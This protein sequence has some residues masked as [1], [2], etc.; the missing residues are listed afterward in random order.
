[1]LSCRRDV[2]P[3][4]R[5]ALLDEALETEE[6]DNTELLSKYRKRLDRCGSLQET[7]VWMAGGCACRLHSAAYMYV[8][9]HHLGHLRIL[10][11]P[12]CLVTAPQ[13]WCGA[14]AGGGQV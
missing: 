9:L 6:Q 1:M 7:F 4:L 14:V 3:A 10:P 5:R 13:G 2:D 11:M 8:V 12:S